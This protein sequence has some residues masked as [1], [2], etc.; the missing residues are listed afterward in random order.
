[1]CHL[2]MHYSFVGKV[3]LKMLILFDM[4]WA[5]AQSLGKVIWSLERKGL[6][7]GKERTE[8]VFSNNPSFEEEVF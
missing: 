1:M 7:P 5:L 8:K 3:W 2:F 4:S 6:G